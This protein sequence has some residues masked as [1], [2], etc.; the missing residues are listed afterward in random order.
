MSVIL[1]IP[2]LTNDYLCGALDMFGIYLHV[3][4][5]KFRILFLAQFIIIRETTN[6]AAMLNPV[7]GVVGWC[8]GAG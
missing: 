5:K 3:Y 8:N 7:A 2:L 1:S 6:M 4:D